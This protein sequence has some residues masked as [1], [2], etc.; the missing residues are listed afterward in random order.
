M[1]REAR[2][3]DEEYECGAR[4][5]AQP[6]E[7]AESM[8]KGVYERDR[9]LSSDLDEMSAEERLPS[10]NYAAASAYMLTQ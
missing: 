6:S 3:K 9:A 7:L 10:Q 5:S 4:I 8:V 1:A 2:D